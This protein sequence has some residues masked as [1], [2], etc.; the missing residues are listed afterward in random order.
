MLQLCRSLVTAA[1]LALVGGSAFAAECL[2]IP[3]ARKMVQAGQIIPTLKA[4]R[5][6][7][8]VVEGEPIDGRLCA[9]GNA[10]RYVVTILGADGRVIRVSVDARSGAVLGKK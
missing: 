2:P 4:V 1:L 5:A 10:Y 6:A 8:A 7:T 3:Q 9:V